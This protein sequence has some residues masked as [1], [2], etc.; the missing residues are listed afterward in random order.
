MWRTR[1]TRA[2]LIACRRFCIGIVRLVLVGGVSSVICAER[3][4]GIRGRKARFEAFRLTI[5]IG[6]FGQG[7]CRGWRGGV[8]RYP[9]LHKHQAHA[10]HGQGRWFWLRRESTAIVCTGFNGLHWTFVRAE[11]QN[12]MVCPAVRCICRPKRSTWLVERT[13]DI[14]AT[15]PCSPACS[16][17]YVVHPSPP[18]YIHLA[19]PWSY[20]DS[21]PCQ[22]SSS[23]F[24][25]P[26][27]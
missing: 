8:W 24:P 10:R 16:S 5:G 2:S 13:L 26:S 14:H 15:L 7:D 25:P 20:E 19:D 1:K 11:A 3:W 12:M 17:D 9:K 22:S 27:I 6:I 23:P 18:K 21:R 4:I